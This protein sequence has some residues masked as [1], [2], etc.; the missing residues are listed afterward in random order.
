MIKVMVL[1]RRKSGLS[2]EEFYKYWRD[3]H[4]S[5]IKNTPEFTHHIRRYVMNRPTSFPVSVRGF[6]PSNF[7]GILEL[8]T[9][10]PDDVA[11]AFSESRFTDSIDPDY[12][13]FVDLARSEFLVVEESPIYGD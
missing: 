12:G 13:K 4:G 5:L 8:W 2:A 1:V 3:V 7:D 6:Q 11:E 10:T 9:D